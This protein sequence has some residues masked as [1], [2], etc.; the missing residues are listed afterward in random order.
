MDRRIHIFANDALR[1]KDGVFVIVSVPRH[2][3]DE[4]IAA[5]RKLSVER[6]RSVGE[7]VAFFYR[8]SDGNGRPLVIAGVLIRALV[9]EQN[10][11]VER[12]GLFC[13]FRFYLDTVA[14]HRHNFTRVLG[15][16]ENARIV[17]RLFLHA[18]ADDRR[19]GEQERY[20][21]ALHIA[22]HERAVR[23]VVFEER[24]EGCGNGDDL[25]RRNVYVLHVFR[26]ALRIVS[27]VAARNHIGRKRTVL[28]D[29]FDD[30]SDVVFVF[31]HRGKVFDFARHF[32]VFDF[33]VRRFEK[34]VIVDA[35]KNRKR[36]DESDVRPFRRF[37]RTHTPVMRIVNVAHFKARPL[38]GKT[39]GPESVQASLVR[40][41]GKRIDLIH[42]LR[43][44]RRA[45]KFFDGCDD[46]FD[47][48]QIL[49]LHRFRFF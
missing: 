34:A 35:R 4:D 48:N 31:V 41:F 18:G 43:K 32:A 39:A 12:V 40:K 25:P 47:R 33:A 38:A 3:T 5:E 2:K 21:L 17:G 49:R 14:R 30:L 29:T 45:E 7:H 20:R 26:R 11:F 23:V 46:R 44:L 10:V 42:K 36:N 15:F 27:A 37:D 22:A 28:A 8:F 13:A 19:F 1:D 9:F 24:N 16:D 6:R